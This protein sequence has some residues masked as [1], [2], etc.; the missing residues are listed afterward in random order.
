MLSQPGLH[1]SHEGVKGIAAQRGS[2]RYRHASTGA[3]A[4]TPSC[5]DFYLP[6]AFPL[7]TEELQPGD[8]LVGLSCI[9]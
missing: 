5:T 1:G 3:C 2:G 9:R 7:R 4:I 8:H 6:I